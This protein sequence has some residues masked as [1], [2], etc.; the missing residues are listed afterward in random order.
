MIS[1]IPLNG[2]LHLFLRFA[3]RI[4]PPR[5]GFAPAPALASR[6]FAWLRPTS[7]WSPPT[8]TPRTWR[9]TFNITLQNDL[10][11]AGIFDM[12]SRSFYPLSIP[13]A[14]QEVHLARVGQP[15]AQR[16]HAGLWQSGCAGRISQRP[17]LAVRHQEPAIAAGAGQAVSRA[18]QRSQRAADRASLRRRD[19]LP[20]GRRR[21]RASPRPRSTSSATAAARRK[22][23]RWITTAPTRS[24]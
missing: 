16:Q 7:S 20:S 23:G 2:S 24:N 4:S 6:K 10:Q 22:S 1:A 13:G 9:M 19:H 21:R 15:A 3:S 8:P 11:A 5:T 18:G 14:P 12:V 17:R